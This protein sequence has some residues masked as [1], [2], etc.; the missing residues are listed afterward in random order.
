MKSII[1]QILNLYYC[2]FYCRRYGHQFVDTATLAPTILMSCEFLGIQLTPNNYDAISSLQNKHV[3][4]CMNCG[5][6][7]K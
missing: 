1:N 2:L 4:I 7:S 5:V 3:S 6:K